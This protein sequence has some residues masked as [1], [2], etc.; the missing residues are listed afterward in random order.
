MNLGFQITKCPEWREDKSKDS[1]TMLKD[2]VD[3]IKKWE[4]FKKQQDATQL[5]QKRREIR[6]KYIV[7]TQI[8]EDI[9]VKSQKETEDIIYV[10]DEKELFIKRSSS[11]GSDDITVKRHKSEENKRST[12]ASTNALFHCTTSQEMVLESLV[13]KDVSDEKKQETMNLYNGLVY[14]EK[15]ISNENCSTKEEEK[16][17]DKLLDVKECIQKAH[18]IL[19]TGVLPEGKIPGQFSTRVR[20]GIFN[21]QK[22]YYPHFKT[23]NIAE[24]AVQNIIDKYHNHLVNIKREIQKPMTLELLEKIFKVAAVFLFSFLQLHPFSDGNGRLGRLLCSHVL[25]LFSPFPTAI[26]NVFSSTHR[27]DYVQALVNARTGMDDKDIQEKIKN[28]EV[29]EEQDAI[30]IAN[31]YLAASPSDLCALIIE[32]NWYTWRELMNI[33]RQTT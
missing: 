25:G 18:K 17:L 28:E 16:D 20:Y 30:N 2:I 7:H 3:Y 31:K 21:N 4:D 15:L 27:Q 22:Y 14:L 5:D 24:A 13:D 19:T 23:E 1:P 11:S 6:V 8:E 33:D 29:V 32:S 10:I 12:N 26:Y 9:G